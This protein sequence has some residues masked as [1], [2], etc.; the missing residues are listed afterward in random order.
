MSSV[1]REIEPLISKKANK[2]AL[3]RSSFRRHRMAYLMLIPGIAYFVLFHYY[4]MYGLIISFKDFKGS[5][6][7]IGSPWVGFKHFDVLFHSKDFFRIF[8][9][10]LLI[11]FYKLVYFFPVPVVMALLINELN[12]RFVKRA[13]QTVVYFPHFLSW[14]VVGGIVYK[15]LGYDGVINAI[16]ERLGGEQ[17]SFLTDVRWFRSILVASA[18]WKEAGWGT[19]LYLAALCAIDPTLYDAA[20]VDGANRRQQTMYVSLPGIASTFAVLL[21]LRIGSMMTIGFEQI[22]ILYNPLVYEVADVFGTYIYRTGL[23]TGRFSYS[24]AVGMFQSVVSLVLIYV[25][26]RLAN[27]FGGRGIW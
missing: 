20:Y 1:L 22:F 3:L 9:N 12:R 27:R 15:V 16:I 17:I 2:L 25:A 11:N 13:I 8:R 19:I 18:I 4:P 24:T 5:L 6:G 23:L 7:I 14:V 26:N 10:T 21:V